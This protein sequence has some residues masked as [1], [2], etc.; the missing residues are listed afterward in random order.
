M[1]RLDV[2]VALSLSHTT[3]RKLAIGGGASYTR[4]LLYL[5]AVAFSQPHHDD[6]PYWTQRCLRLFDFLLNLQTAYASLDPCCHVLPLPLH[7]MRVLNLRVALVVWLR[8][9]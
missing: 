4:L 2:D 7:R 3:Q 5:K 9:Y 8:Q 1:A 6:R